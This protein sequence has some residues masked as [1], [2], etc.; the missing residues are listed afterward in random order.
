[1]ITTGSVI[2]E[3]ESYLSEYCSAWT[4]STKVPG[5]ISHL[6]AFSNSKVTYRDDGEIFLLLDECDDPKRFLLDLSLLDT[7]QGSQKKTIGLRHPTG[8]L[9]LDDRGWW[10]ACWDEETLEYFVIEEWRRNLNPSE[11][12]QLTDE[13][14]QS[15]MDDEDALWEIEW[16]EAEPDYVPTRNLIQRQIVQY[17]HSEAEDMLNFPLLN[18]FFESTWHTQPTVELLSPLP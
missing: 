12:K 11:Q 4:E 7:L 5:P 14:A 8:V 16:P 2:S 9:V 6:E 15:D 3:P 10:E 1:M 17:L 18:R 13:L